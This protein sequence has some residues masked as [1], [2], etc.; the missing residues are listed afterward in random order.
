MTILLA[1]PTTPF[2][3][4]IRTEKYGG[5]RDPSF[6]ENT[7]KDDKMVVCDSQVRFPR[8][9]TRTPMLSPKEIPSQRVK[10]LSSMRKKKVTFLT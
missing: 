2:T 6:K 5:V 10:R 9:S 3:S 1:R 4:I 8:G 7:L